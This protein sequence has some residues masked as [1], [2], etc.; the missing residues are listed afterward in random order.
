MCGARSHA[1]RGVDAAARVRGGL[2]AHKTTS[3]C[4]TKLSSSRCVSR[5]FSSPLSRISSYLV[6]RPTTSKSTSRIKLVG[7]RV[8]LRFWTALRT[9]SRSESVFCFLA[10]AADLTTCPKRGTTTAKDSAK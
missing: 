9:R 7:N 10:F 4:L 5:L 3:F 8:I 2:L 1:T 6:I